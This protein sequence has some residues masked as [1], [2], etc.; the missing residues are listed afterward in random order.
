MDE[1]KPE[2]KNEIPLMPATAA[3]GVPGQK[4]PSIQYQESLGRMLV[5][6]QPDFTGEDWDTF[7]NYAKTKLAEGIVN[8]DLDLR[9]LQLITSMFLGSIIGFNMVIQ[10]RKGVLRL[11]T[12][13]N[14]RISKLI[15]MSKIDRII[16]VREV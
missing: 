16:L 2:D 12:E 13:K 6:L 15:H 3:S 9:R 5:E 10:S 1:Q 7:T 14:S 8:W 11:V 4:N